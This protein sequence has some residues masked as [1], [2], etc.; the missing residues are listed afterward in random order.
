MAIGLVF[1][2][3]VLVTAV[4]FT[5]GRTM[6]ALAPIASEVPVGRGFELLVDPLCALHD[7]RLREVVSWGEDLLVGFTGGHGTWLMRDSFAHRRLEVAGHQ[8]DVEGQLCFRNAARDKRTRRSLELWRDDGRVLVA[9]I[10]D[11]IGVGALVDESSSEALT[12][13]VAYLVD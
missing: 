9:V 1:L 2:F 13:D 5:L 11:R 10:N 8:V 3:L 4:W 12:V 7:V 6:L